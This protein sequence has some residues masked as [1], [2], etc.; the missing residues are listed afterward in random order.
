[1]AYVGGT[2]SFGET[3]VDSISEAV[4]LNRKDSGKI[5][6]VTDS[7]G[8]GYTITLPTPANAGIGW[9][10]KFI[11]N[12]AVGSTLNGSGGEDVVLN[13]GQTDVMVVNYVDSADASTASVVHD[14]QADT[15]GFDNTCVKGDFIDLFSDGTTWFAFGISGADGGILV[16]T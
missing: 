13:D 7:G 11:V 3:R 16:A 12:A 9:S 1:M 8:S 2:P 15:V 14:R 10:A 4:T 6:M 5:F